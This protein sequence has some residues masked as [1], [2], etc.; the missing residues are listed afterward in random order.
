[1]E[2]RSFPSIFAWGGSHKTLGLDHLTPNQRAALHD[3][4]F[5]VWF[6]FN[7]DQPQQNPLMASPP[8]S[9]AIFPIPERPTDNVL[10]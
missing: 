5:G 3:L 7:W 1:M 8:H 6:S 10:T 4:D 2:N 9:L